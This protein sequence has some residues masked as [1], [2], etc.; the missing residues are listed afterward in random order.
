MLILGDS[1]LKHIDSW[2]QETTK[3]GK[4]TEVQVDVKCFRGC[5]FKRLTQ[6]ISRN[7]VAINNYNS[8]IIHMGTND[9]DTY[10]NS[11]ANFNFVE[12]IDAIRQNNSQA[13]IIVSTPL[14]RPRDHRTSY[15][16]LK[17]FI[18]WLTDN[19]IKGQYQ[20]WRTD[21]PFLQKTRNGSETPPIRNRMDYHRD[22]LHLSITGAK[23]LS[24][25][26]KMAISH[27]T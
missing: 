2:Q 16:K 14:P 1:I 26:L 24:Q 18:K 9:L 19:K 13:N 20:T 12:T 23:K 7:S 15:P 17:K 5:T 27:L 11:Q 22:G 21:K 25:Q 3:L 10:S 8:I 4:V 6:K